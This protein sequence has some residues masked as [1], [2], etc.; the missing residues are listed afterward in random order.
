PPQ[1]LPVS[2]ANSSTRYGR[3]GIARDATSGFVILHAASDS[4]RVMVAAGVNGPGS[5]ALYGPSSGIDALSQTAVAL[6]GAQW[7]FFAIANKALAGASLQPGSWSFSGWQGFQVS[8][9]LSAVVPLADPAQ[10]CVLAL[11]AEP[12]GPNLWAARASW[13]LSGG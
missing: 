3:L 2:G 10:G 11:D 7:V 6:D 9:Q 13:P 5:G 1:L 8:P 4:G 12:N